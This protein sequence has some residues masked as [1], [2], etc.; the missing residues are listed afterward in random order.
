MCIKLGI[1]IKK[2]DPIL[3][4]FLKNGL[5]K[6]SIGKEFVFVILLLYVVSCLL[7]FGF[8]FLVFIFLFVFY[9]TKYF[10]PY[11]NCNNS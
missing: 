9:L 10:V 4:L 8:W 1:I 3:L 6:R 2:N 5:K 11:V 7:V